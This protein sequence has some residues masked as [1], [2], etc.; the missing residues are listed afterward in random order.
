MN[1]SLKSI[2]QSLTDRVK[3]WIS[4]PTAPKATQ[5]PSLEGATLLITHAQVSNRHGTGSLLSK[6]FAREHALIT[7]Y[8]RDYFPQ[9]E[10]A[11]LSLHV[12]HHE[13]SSISAAKSKVA[14]LLG[15]S[16]I[17]RIFCVPFYP[18]DVVSALAAQELTG[19]PIVSYVM[20]DQNVFTEGISDPL[21]RSLVQASTL[22]FVISDTLREGY[23][24][25]YGVPF[26]ILPPV[27]SSQYFVP[28]TYEYAKN[29]PPKGV[30]IG[31]LWNPDIINQFRQTIQESGLEVAW[32]GNAGKPFYDL[33]SAELAKE[34]IILHPHLSDEPLVQ[35]LRTFD[36]AIMPSGPL[37]GSDASHDWLFRAS[38]P[39]RLIYLMTTT[40]LPIIVLGHPETAAAKFITK[41]ELGACCQYDGA[42]FRSA[43]LAV[44]SPEISAK[45]NRTARNIAPSFASEPVAAWIWASLDKGAP[46][47][48]RY[49][50][51]FSKARTPL[52]V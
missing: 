37:D 8:S 35:A 19:A 50:R 46:A 21:M 13:T 45:I 26:W 38:L 51:L 47:D 43:V 36:Y 9:S 4:R 41:F 29:N 7:F 14:V 44:T 31:N 11:G 23:S 16:T 48:D 2:H 32:Y 42:S 30:L 33:D 1:I 27:A 22:R 34:G 10:L 6:I 52:E 5:S 49:E 15:K 20:D 12:P 3:S 25:K 17:R 24:S 18:D 40:N 39:S 28:E